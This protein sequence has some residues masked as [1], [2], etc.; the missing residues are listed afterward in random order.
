MGD[1][2]LMFFF[3]LGFTVGGM[4]G[5]MVYIMS[6]GTLL[7]QAERAIVE[8]EKTLPRNESCVV[9]AVRVEQDGEKN[10]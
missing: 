7:D 6:P 10:E 3:T 8:C 5:V 1:C 2:P 9:T 4:F